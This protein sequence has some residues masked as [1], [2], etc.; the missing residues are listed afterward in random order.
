MLHLTDLTPE[1]GEIKRCQS[2]HSRVPDRAGESGSRSRLQSRSVA[3]RYRRNGGTDTFSFSF[4]ALRQRPSPVKK[5]PGRTMAAPADKHESD[6][7]VRPPRGAGSRIECPRTRL[8]RP[9]C[10]AVRGSLHTLQRSLGSG[11][12]YFPEPWVRGFAPQGG[13]PPLLGK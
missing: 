8:L 6:Y 3:R 12:A 9:Q 2:R 7:G 13:S 4:F 1:K 11:P 10:Q 5:K